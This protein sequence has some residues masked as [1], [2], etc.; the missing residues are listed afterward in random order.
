MSNIKR[1]WNVELRTGFENITYEFACWEEDLSAPERVIRAMRFEQEVVEPESGAPWPT[2]GHLPI[3]S[4]QGLMDAMWNAGIRPSDMDEK[5][6]DREREAKDEHLKDLRRLLFKHGTSDL[7][8]GGL[9]LGSAL[10]EVNAEKG[11]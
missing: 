5:M 7:T 1:K 6:T 11:G 2:A 3:E 9:V 10:D 8:E 4:A